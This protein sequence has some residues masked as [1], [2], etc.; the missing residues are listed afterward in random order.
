MNP[1]KA[2]KSY[3]CSYRQG[4]QEDSEEEADDNQEDEHDEEASEAAPHDEL[5]GLAGVGEPEE[6]GVRPTGGGNVNSLFMT[7][8]ER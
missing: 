4:V 3:V 7:D 6:R 1:S 5:H 2:T 8:G